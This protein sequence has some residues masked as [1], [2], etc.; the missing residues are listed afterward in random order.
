MILAGWISPIR[1]GSLVIAEINGKETICE[2][3]DGGF[4]SGKI[5]TSIVISGD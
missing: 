2:V 3:I 5:W 4:N 1:P